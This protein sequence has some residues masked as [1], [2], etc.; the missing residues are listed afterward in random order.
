MQRATFPAAVG[1][2]VE[3]S[4]CSIAGSLEVPEKQTRQL[5]RRSEAKWPVGRA[6]ASVRAAF[7]DA[8]SLAYGAGN[9][10]T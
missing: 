10:T 5:V 8:A 3:F 9:I 7:I 2:R 6:S 4:P 1:E